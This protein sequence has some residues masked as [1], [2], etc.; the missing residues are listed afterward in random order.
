MDVYYDI[1]RSDEC[2]PLGHSVNANIVLNVPLIAARAWADTSRAKDNKRS[3]IAC[4]VRSRSDRRTSSG[5]ATII[6]AYAEHA[7][8]AK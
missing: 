5:S 6:P 2:V 4:T 8:S 1:I 7:D 3:T